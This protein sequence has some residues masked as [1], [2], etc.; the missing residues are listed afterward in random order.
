MVVESVFKDVKEIRSGYL[1]RDKRNR[2]NN[3]STFPNE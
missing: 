1:K 2:E 3:V